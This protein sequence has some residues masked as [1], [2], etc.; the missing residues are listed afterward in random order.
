VT[1][2]LPAARPRSENRT[3]I[4]D[5]Y[6]H[7]CWHGQPTKDGTVTAV[8]PRGYQPTTQYAN[9]NTKRSRNKVRITPKRKGK[10][11]KTYACTDSFDR[12]E[13]AETQTVSPSGQVVT[14]LGWPEDPE[15]SEVVTASVETTLPALE[16]L[17]GAPIPGDGLTI[18]EVASQALGGYAGDFSNRSGNVRVS[19][20]TEDP[21]VIT[22]ELA[23][24]W[25]NDRTLGAK[26]MFEGAAEWVARATNGARCDWRARPGADEEVPKLR[27]WRHLGPEP[28]DAERDFVS[29]QY[30]LACDIY[31]RLESLLGIEGVRA[32]NTALLER[33][34]KYGGTVRTKPPKP[35]WR[36]WLDAVDELGMISDGW[37]A[38]TLVEDILIDNGIARPKD[39]EGRV[40]A[41]RL[42]HSSLRYGLGEH[43]PVV[44]RDLLDD[45]RFEKATDALAIAEAIVSLA[46]EYDRANDADSS[47]VIG[48]RLATANTVKA[49]RQLRKDVAA[50]PAVMVAPEPASS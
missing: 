4:T 28:T 48:A 45:W 2:Q 27:R 29:A 33:T 43:M 12:D 37:S 10:P 25:F 14:V 19:E 40:D 21:I 8:L 46:G 22:H 26:W 20:D 17:I 9:V 6:A 7:F 13:V 44:V 30:F 39:L 31:E 1:Y 16:Q 3:R 32:V 42:Y 49:L 24:A 5:A 38:S 35:D 34:P 47:P 15:W 23:H 41:R 18:L 11:G 36:E 50:D